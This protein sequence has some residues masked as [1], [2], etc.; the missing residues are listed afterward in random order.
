MTNI[1]FKVI[2]LTRPG[3]EPLDTRFETTI[4]GSPDL[5]DGRRA[6]YSFGH[7]DWLMLGDNVLQLSSVC[8][9]HAGEAV[10]NHVQ[11]S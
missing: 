3:F 6:L 1:N 11:P 5:Q 8:K 2:G 7:P 10:T 9:D 4:V